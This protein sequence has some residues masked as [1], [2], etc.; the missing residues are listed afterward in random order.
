VA[1][2]APV[3]TTVPGTHTITVTA[4][5]SVGQTATASTTYTVMEKPNVPPTATITSPTEGAVYFQGQP[6]PAAYTCADTDGTVVSCTGPVPAGSNVDTA[7]VGSKAFTVVATDDDGAT[8]TATVHY[9]VVATKGVCRGNPL[10]LLG[11][12]LG[13]ANAKTTPCATATNKVVDG[14]V[15]YITPPIP[16]LGVAGNFVQIGVLTGD[17]QAGA[18]SAAAQAQ[19]ANVKISLLG[20]TIVATGLTSSASS[21]LSACSTPAALSGRSSIA[22]LTINN[23][24]VLNLGQ[25][26]S[27]PLLIGSLNL[28]ERTVTGSTIS[29]SALHLDVAGL[30]DLRLGQ[31]LA[32]ATC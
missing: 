5:D 25:P 16:L 3:D 2:G 1:L 6:V 29:Q 30:V 22:S 14:S 32:G 18:G 7:S 15:I 28:N 27:I 24:P 4:T 31:S 11:L 10:S 9:T 19:V 23:K 13:N 17:T 8:G 26:I 12:H 20:Q 21:T